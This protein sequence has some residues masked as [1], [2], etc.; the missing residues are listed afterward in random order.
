MEEPHPAAGV[1]ASD[2][3]PVLAEWTLGIVPEWDQL[4]VSSLE[5]AASL[6]RGCWCA[7]FLLDRD[8]QRLVLVSFSGPEPHCSPPIR[9]LFSDSIEWKASEGVGPV[10]LLAPRPRWLGPHPDLGGSDLYPVACVP[11]DVEGTRFG[12]AEV[13]R[14]PGSDP[15]CPE[16][17]D[18]L[19]VVSRHL[20]LWLSNSAVLRR[21]REL[22]IT[23]GLTGVYNHRYFQDRLGLE[24][25]RAAR[26]QRPLSLIM[27][28]LNHFKRYND[29]FGHQGGD[30]ALRTISATIQR[31]VRRIDVVARYGGD[32]FAVI[33]PETVAPQALVVAA[34]IDRALR[35]QGL[36]FRMGAETGRLSL[37]MG[38][39]SYPDLAGNREELIARADEALYRAKR[40]PGRRIV[41]WDA[42]WI[43]ETPEAQRAEGLR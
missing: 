7:L 15:F 23:D 33:L 2:E 3:S 26:Y 37:C 8:R 36:E 43:G 9:E 11:V 35:A 4:L 5:M 39:S 32:E 34:R 38:I 40:G 18:R 1:V 20:A 21:L 13:V 27:M 6:M 10:A 19:R 30:E 25:E 12:V 22:A 29:L 28:D 16:E 24:I 42:A 17:V 14:T 41:I 31:E